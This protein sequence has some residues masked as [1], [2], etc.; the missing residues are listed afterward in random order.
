T[1]AACVWTKGATRLGSNS[2][3]ECLVS[4]EWCGLA[5]AQPAKQRVAYP[6][7]TAARE[8]IR[9]EETRIFDGLMG[10][11]RAK[12]TL[13]GVRV[14]MQQLMERDVGIFRDEAG[15]SDACGKL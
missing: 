13:A 5:A 12:E 4:G 2:P 6:R 9:K 8:A 11:E 14:E 10:R 15:L 3:R 7:G 1:G